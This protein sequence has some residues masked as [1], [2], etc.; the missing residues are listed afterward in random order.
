[1]MSLVQAHR[2]GSRMAALRIV[3]IISA[4]CT[5]QTHILASRNNI[6]APR[7]MAYILDWEPVCLGSRELSS[8]NIE[9]FSCI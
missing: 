9:D 1:M 7:E 4:K 8:R 6:I 2:T 3:Y 5:L